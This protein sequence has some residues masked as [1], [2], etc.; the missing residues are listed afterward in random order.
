MDW[1]NDRII[2]TTKKIRP[3]SWGL[4]V[5]DRGISSRGTDI[6]THF[7]SDNVSAGVKAKKADVFLRTCSL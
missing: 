5:A 3:R 7:L 2:T 6:I 1:G 4:S